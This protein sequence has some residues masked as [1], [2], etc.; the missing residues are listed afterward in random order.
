MTPAEL[1][2]IRERAETASRPDAPSA[3]NTTSVGYN[4]LCR[5]HSEMSEDALREAFAWLQERHRDLDSLRVSAVPALLAEVDRL[6]GEI[7]DALVGHIDR[8]TERDRDAK[9]IADLSALIDRATT[10]T[11]PL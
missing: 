1:E 10:V 2:S 3:F 4:A 5:D 8:T 7:R 9:L 6:R 11:P